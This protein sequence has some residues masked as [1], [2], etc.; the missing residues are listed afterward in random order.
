MTTPINTLPNE[1]SL[2]R[3]LAVTEASYGAGGTPVFQ[4]YG[5]LVINKKHP[6][7]RSSDEARGSFSRNRNPRRGPTAIDGTFGKPIGFEDLD[8][9]KRYFL[10]K[11][12]GSRTDDTNTVHG[13]TSTASANDNTLDSW[14]AEHFVDGIPFVA[15]GIQMNEVTISGDID[16]ADGNWML[17]SNL[18]VASDDLKATTS[19]TATGGSTTTLVKSAAGW[20]VNQWAGAYA[21]ARSGTAANL[22]SVVKV[23]SNDAT[24]LTFDSTLNA[25]VVSTDVW[26]LSGLFTPSIADRT[27]HYIPNEGTQLFIDDAFGSIGTTEWTD[28]LISFSWTIAHGFS[29]KRFMN[30]VGV[31]AKK[32]GRGDRIVTVQLTMEF[33]DWYEYKKWDT[34]VPSDRAI[35][36]QN[37]GP[38]IDSGASS[39]YLAQLDLPRAQWDEVNP[40]NQREGNITAVYQALAYVDSSAG[41][42]TAVTTKTAMA[43]LLG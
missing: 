11:G 9:L 5:D 14:A 7:I 21:A 3:V 17:S 42:E 36:I 28:K 27:I 12:G 29:R 37:I 26:E 10:K 25:A 24:T 16:N 40:N 38:V 18:I 4:M 8:Q 19:V 15:T 23:L 20:T 1:Q 2:K 43:T 13:Y 31:Y 32:Q 35:R 33:D 22:Q 6:L 30:N 41:Y 39:H 34:S